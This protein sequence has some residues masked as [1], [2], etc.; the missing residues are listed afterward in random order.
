MLRPHRDRLLLF[1]NPLI[2]EATRKV[3]KSGSEENRQSR[4]EFR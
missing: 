1:F 2:N 4:H 3:L